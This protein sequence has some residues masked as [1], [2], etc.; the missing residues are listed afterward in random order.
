MLRIAIFFI[1]P[2]ISINQTR[3]DKIAK[4]SILFYKYFFLPMSQTQYVSHL[5]FTRLQKISIWILRLIWSASAHFI[6]TH[7]S[8]LPCE[9]DAFCDSVQDEIL[10]NFVFSFAFL[11]T[12]IFFYFLWSL[13]SLQIDG[14][15]NK[16]QKVWKESLFFWKIKCFSRGHERFWSRK[17]IRSRVVQIELGQNWRA[18]LLS[19]LAYIALHLVFMNEIHST[20]RNWL[21]SFRKLWLIRY[22]DPIIQAIRK[23]VR[24]RV[25]FNRIYFFCMH[26][27]TDGID[28][29]WLEALFL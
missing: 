21:F 14:N 18:R 9:C 20:K 4:R 17:F 29:Q 19:S 5:F 22:R 7:F 16:T 24:V 3:P 2:A 15:L 27:H 10:S 13:V 23:R 25:N 26:S 1:L 12:V 28:L 6:L 11:Q 8:F